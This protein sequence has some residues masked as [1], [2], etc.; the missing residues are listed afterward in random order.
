LIVQDNTLTKLVFTL[1]LVGIAGVSLGQTVRY[2]SDEFQ[3]PVREEPKEDS[4]IV[5]LIASGTRVEVLSQGFGGFS[6]VRTEGLEGWVRKRDLMDIP[7]GR[8]RLA[9]AEKRFEERR[10]ALEQREQEVKEL[11]AA[12]D[13]LSEGNDALKNRNRQL[14]DELAGL[15]KRTAKPLATERDNRRLEL[16]LQQERGTVRTLMDENDTLKAQAIRDWFLIGAGVAL[17]SLLLGVIIARIPWRG[18]KSW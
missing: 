13:D 6:L 12:V 9:A 18:Q 1:C 17:A 10:V 8:A 15:R 7:S 3:V 5:T 4:R 14:E 11:R 2:V 16:A